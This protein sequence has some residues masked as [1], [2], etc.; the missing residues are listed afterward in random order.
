MRETNNTAAGLLAL[1]FAFCAA[2]ADRPPRASHADAPGIDWFEGDVGSAFDAATRAGKPVF[3]YWGAKWCPPCQQLKSSVFS[4]A[5]FIAKTRQFVAVYLDGDE[6]GAQKWGEKFHVLGYPTVVVLRADQREITRLSGGI[7]LSL[8]AD[9]LDAALG[10]VEPMSEV[11]ATLKQRP[12]DLSAAECRRLAYYDWDVADFTTIDKVS[13]A[14]ALAQ[15]A[16]TCAGLSPVERARFTVIS[17]ALAPT[18][19]TVGAVMRLV[20]DPALSLRVAD[21]IED[22]GASFYTALDAQGGPTAAQFQH[23]W[24]QL[25]DTVANDP[26]VIDADQLAAL[27]KKLELV[28]HF[29]PDHVV[30]AELAA[31]AR[32]RVAA[33]LAKPMD[34]YV[35]AGVVNSASFVYD[36]LADEA[37][38]YSMLEAELATAKAPYYYMVDLGEIEEKRGHRD[39]ALAWYA[40]AYRESRGIATR[41]QWGCTYL[42][43]LLRLAPQDRARIRRVGLDVIGELDGPDRIQARTRWRLEKLD[44][45]LRDWSTAQHG[46]AEIRALHARMASVCTKLPGADSGLASCRKF[47]QTAG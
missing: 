41:F 13:I 36:Q 17:A 31:A 15:T 10:D 8:Y 44:A 32:T 20:A 2:A 37:A 9:L 43:A 25:M 38:E 40:R 4:R 39:A 19:Q 24:S 21:V 6:P 45:S 35:R 18:P 5:D 7:D 28:K 27:G 33:V 47:L 23:D 12:A 42:Q 46:A 22:L 30:P 34:P 1:L 16:A 3:L 11:L 29:A 26:R 14:A